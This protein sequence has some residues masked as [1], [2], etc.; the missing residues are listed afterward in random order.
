MGVGQPGQRHRAGDLAGGFAGFL[1]TP[2]TSPTRPT[3]PR[4]RAIVFLVWLRV[5]AEAGCGL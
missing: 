3:A 1:C 4:P 5:I 2:P